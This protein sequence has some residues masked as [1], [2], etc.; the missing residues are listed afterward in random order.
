MSLDTKTLMEAV[1]QA[2]EKSKKRNFTQSIEL[3]MNLREIDMK[4]PESKIQE[5]IELPRPLGK[6]G[7]VCVIA[8]GELALKA[9]KAGADLVLERAE[10]EAMSGDKKQ[11]KKLAEEYDFFIAEAPL[12]PLVGKVLGAI[13]G[14]RAK[15]PTPVPPTANIEELLEKRRRMVLVRTRGQPILQCAVGTEDMKDEEIV[16]NIQTVLRVIE[17]KLKRGIKNI[18]SL[19]LKTS[20]GSTVKIKI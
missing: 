7:K 17:G 18:K 10:L 4:K 11:Q 13:L 12:M 8:S 2:K 1:K 6:R 14:P 5:L 16:E 19:C 20:M 9:K 15:M 3:I